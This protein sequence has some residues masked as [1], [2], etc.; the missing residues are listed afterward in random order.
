M[1]E[2]IANHKKG[3]ALANRKIKKEELQLANEAFLPEVI[4]LLN[5]GHSITLP[6]RG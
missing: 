1:K 4:Q 3:D 6:L 2:S 5:E